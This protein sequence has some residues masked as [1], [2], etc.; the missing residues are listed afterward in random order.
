MT[1]ADSITGS[2]KAGGFGDNA[3]ALPTIPPA[4][5]QQ[6]KRTFDPLRNADIFTRHRQRLMNALSLP[7]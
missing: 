7:E 4:P 2:P 1:N 3:R 6:P 5:Q